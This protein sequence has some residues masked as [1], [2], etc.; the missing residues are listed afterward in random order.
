[1][2]KK[3][4]EELYNYKRLI[5]ELLGAVIA[6][7]WIA[8]ALIWPGN[9]IGLVVAIAITIV[10]GTLSGGLIAL[11]TNKIDNKEAIGWVLGAAIGVAWIAWA[12]LSPGNMVGLVV[13]IAI[14][15]VFGTLSGGFISLSKKNIK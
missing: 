5:G 2:N 3:K 12:L 10:S 14:T 15:I 13:A 4:V 9:M 6:V 1:M 8:W 11:S 7:A